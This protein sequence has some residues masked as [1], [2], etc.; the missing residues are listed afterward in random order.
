MYSPQSDFTPVLIYPT[1][2]PFPLLPSKTRTTTATWDAVAH[3]AEQMMDGYRITKEKGW[4]GGNGEIN[5]EI[6]YWD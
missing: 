1:K 2:I 6:G 5:G 3:R 4:E